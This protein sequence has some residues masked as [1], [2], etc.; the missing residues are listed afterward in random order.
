MTRVYVHKQ[1]SEQ[2]HV[3]Y[4]WGFIQIKTLQLYTHS[5]ESRV[6]MRIV[7]CIRQMDLTELS[8]INQSKWHTGSLPLHK[9]QNHDT[10]A[11]TPR[12]GV[13]LSMWETVRTQKGVSVL[14]G[15][16]SLHK[17]THKN[18]S[19]CMLLRSMYFFMLNYKVCFKSRFSFGT[20][21]LKNYYKK[22][23]ESK[24]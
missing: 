10:T 16:D 8:K 11:W 3:I 9:I 14:L 20:N 17:N 23:S 1:F 2:T 7:F 4:P 24:I 19:A 18:S 12:S 13:K 22:V 21:T 15:L 6:G 5:M